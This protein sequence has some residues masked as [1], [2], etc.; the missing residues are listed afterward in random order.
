MTE[1]KEKPIVIGLGEVLW[2]CFE[3]GR[4]PGGAP[5]NVAFQA[6]QLGL[7]G[8]IVSRIGDDAL[9][10]ELLAFLQ[11]QG[12]STDLIQHDSSHPTGTVTVDK[13]I[14]T[15][16]VYTIHRNVAW[17]FLEF[18]DSLQAMTEKIAAVCFGTLAQRSPTTRQTIHRFLDALPP[19]CLRV[20]DVNLRQNDYSREILKTS[21]QKAD[22][23]KMN[24]EEWLVVAELFEQKRDSMVPFCQWLSETFRIPR[25]CIT[26]GGDG[27]LMVESN[28]EEGA[29]HVI[30]VP[31]EK[32]EVADT[33]GSGDAFTA[34]W[35]DA[36]LHQA[37]L[38]LQ[39]MFANAVGTLV[40]T[41]AGGMPILRE[42][43]EI[44]RKEMGV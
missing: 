20:Y 42:E 26:R 18:T 2:D 44:L 12:L 27:C 37:P 35:I 16:P 4:K 11:S 3:E 41:R 40:A 38:K 32:V 22:V 17:E 15:A 6:N 8:R 39:A 21:F 43:L 9:G 24:D 34:A 13:S 30:E 25:I 36:L 31:G 14:S 33:I 29:F 19:S 10:E 28:P 23:V 5:A 1:K 7:D